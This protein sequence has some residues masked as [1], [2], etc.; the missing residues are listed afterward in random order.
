M[1]TETT[2]DATRNHSQGTTVFVYGHGPENPF[3]KAAQALKGN[4]GDC[5]LILSAPV[6]RGQRLLLMAG[7]KQS[8]V[9]AEIVTTRSLGNRRFEV[10]VSF[11]VAHPDFW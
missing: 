4:S 9:E 5:L 11:P 7:A 8:P 1:L 6:S 10:E 3:F 2:K